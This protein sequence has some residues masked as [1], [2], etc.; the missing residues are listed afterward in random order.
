MKLAAHT[1]NISL[2]VLYRLISLWCA[3]IYTPTEAQEVT[4][5][6][7]TGMDEDGREAAR[8]SGSTVAQADLRG[9]GHH[10]ENSRASLLDAG[11]FALRLRS[12]C[13]HRA[14]KRE[15]NQRGNAYDGHDAVCLLVSLYIG[16]LGN[17]K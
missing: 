2:N 13:K 15:E 1:A 12:L 10:L 8:N 3:R 7:R 4:V 16:K 9:S 11:F 5:F 6:Y 14:R 17:R